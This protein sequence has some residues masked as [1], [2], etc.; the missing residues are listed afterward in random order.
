MGVIVNNAGQQCFKGHR[1]QRDIQKKNNKATSSNDLKN[2]KIALEFSI[3]LAV[4]YIPYVNSWYGFYDA[5]V[6]L[7][8]SINCWQINNC[9][10]YPDAA[11]VVFYKK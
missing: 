9:S 4:L 2:V 1:W 6:P 11:T 7:S 10:L 8:L 5:V 3:F